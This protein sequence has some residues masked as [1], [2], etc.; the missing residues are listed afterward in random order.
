MT[1]STNET[2]VLVVHTEE[3][4]LPGVD[5]PGTHQRY[6]NPHT[7]IETRKLGELSPDFIRVQMVYAGV[8]GTDVHLVQSN[9]DSGYVL[10]SAPADIPTEGRVMGHEGVGRIMA[11]GS[12]VKHVKPGDF[13]AFESIVTCHHCEACRRG[14]FNQCREALLLG[15]QV[16]GLF[17]TVV[18]VPASLAHDVS[19]LSERGTGLMAAACLEP[20]GVAWLA[21]EN[22]R[23]SGGDVVLIF[24]GGPIGIYCAM[25]CKT[26]LGASCVYLVDP[27]EKR[28]QLAS[29]WCDQVS[30]I[31]MFFSQDTLSIDVVIEASGCLDNVQ[32]A[33]RRIR[34]NGRVVLL[35]RSGA[36]LNLDAVDHMITHAISIMGSRGHLGG[37]FE[38]IL[39]LYRSGRLPLEVVVT[40]VLDSL[41][42]LAGLLK[43]ADRIV[44]D[45]CKVLVKLSNSH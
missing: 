19:D 2:R 3:A 10:S 12:H 28:R 23:V 31:E 8:C 18:D 36:P 16:D 20:A 22:A 37:A 39:S 11:C 4:E 9:P 26:I 15:M 27:I 33:F 43:A 6:R 5:C 35:A 13:V 34:E 30:D 17:G 38:K 24:G 44:N 14:A 25:L 41:D 42:T 32:R 21:C 40:D 45:Q 7:S 29:E 1:V